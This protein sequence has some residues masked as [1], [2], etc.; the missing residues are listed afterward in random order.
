[1]DTSTFDMLHDTW[2]ENICPSEMASTAFLSGDIGVNKN[3]MV[4]DLP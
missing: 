3:W 1:M 2:N 4:M